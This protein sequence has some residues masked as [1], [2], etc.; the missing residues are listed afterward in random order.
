MHEMNVKVKSIYDRA[1]DADGLRVYVEKR[2]PTRRRWASLR[3][4]RHL[5]PLAPS[6]ELSPALTRDPEGWKI[7]RTAY[8]HELMHS[9]AAQELLA[10][11][12]REARHA[13]LT[14]LYEKLDS[15]HNA[16]R[17][18]E[19]MLKERHRAHRPPQG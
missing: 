5:P 14:L 10:D 7:F 13:P 3:V 15:R 11:L 18:V 4:N 16:A 2:K 12:R 19:D 17:V 6:A 8:E 9:P 1:E